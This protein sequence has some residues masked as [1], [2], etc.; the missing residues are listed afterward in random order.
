[1]FPQIWVPK[2]QDAG[3]SNSADKAVMPDPSKEKNNNIAPESQI[4]VDN[5]NPL[6][7]PIQKTQNRSPVDDKQ[8]PKA[9]MP[10]HKNL[11]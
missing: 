1:M 4:P 3:S 9:I 6:S 5:T 7:P 11:N 2:G 8:K 10:P